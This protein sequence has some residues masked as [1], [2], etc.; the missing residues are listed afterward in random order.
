MEQIL[1]NFEKRVNPKIEQEK[2]EKERLL[3]KQIQNLVKYYYSHLLGMIILCFLVFGS[4]YLSYIMEEQVLL[5]SMSI[6]FFV[7]VSVC[8]V[9]IKTLNNLNDRLENKVTL[10]DFLCEWLQ[11]N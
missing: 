8:V 11:S 7:F 1:S 2:K 5:I 6:V 3:N 9:M 4:V 10:K